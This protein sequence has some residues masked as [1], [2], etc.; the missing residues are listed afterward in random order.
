MYIHLNDATLDAR[1]FIY[2]CAMSMQR[3]SAGQKQRAKVG[4]KK[5]NLEL[6]LIIISA[7]WRTPI[8]KVDW[9]WRY[10]QIQNQLIFFQVALHTIELK[11]SKLLA[12]SCQFTCLKPLL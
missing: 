9:V 8:Y 12:Q 5:T 4:E 6:I 1:A 11:Q 3:H 7:S 2:Q 10:M